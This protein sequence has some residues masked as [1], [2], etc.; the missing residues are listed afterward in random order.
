[1]LRLVDQPLTVIVLTNLE[2]E[3]RHPR[4]MA[5]AVMGA[6]R[7]ELRPPDMLPPAADPDAEFTR[8]VLALLADVGGRRASPV[9]SAAY[10]AR[11]KASIGEQAVMAKQLGGAGPVAYLAHDDLGGRS[12]WAGEPLSR[13]V[14]YSTMAGGR[15]FFLSVGVNADRHV[16]SLDFQVK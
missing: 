11:Y 15:T 5:R 3:D 14:H 8:S 7:G 6:V 13:L 16:A 2:S 4:V 10:A 1:M 12:L 9:M